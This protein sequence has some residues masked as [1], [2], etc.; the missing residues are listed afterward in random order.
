MM[1]EFHCFKFFA[2]II[3]TIIA[4][5]KCLKPIMLGINNACYNPRV[6][7]IAAIF[8]IMIVESMFLNAGPVRSQYR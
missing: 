4:E 8:A 2:V 7:S 3:A 1:N 6:D 5:C